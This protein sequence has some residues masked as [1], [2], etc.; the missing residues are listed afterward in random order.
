[1]YTVEWGILFFAN[2]RLQ[3]GGRLPPPLFENTILL[4]SP[5]SLKTDTV[6]F[7][8]STLNFETR[9]FVC[10]VRVSKRDLWARD[11]AQVSRAGLYMLRSSKAFEIRCQDHV[12][13]IR[14][15]G[16]RHGVVDLQFQLKKVLGD[17]RAVSVGSAFCHAA[18]AKGEDEAWEEPY[19]NTGDQSNEFGSFGVRP[20]EEGLE[21]S[22]FR[23]GFDVSAPSGPSL[24]P[25]TIVGLEDGG[26]MPAPESLRHGVFLRRLQDPDHVHMRLGG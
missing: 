25:L 12:S 4:F 10:G 22:G 9:T 7:E 23:V 14:F 3:N 6:Q 20:T 26:Y 8:V 2:R 13:M 24:S 16:I 19:G 1:M 11:F 18:S 5:R 15:W 17:I 21:I